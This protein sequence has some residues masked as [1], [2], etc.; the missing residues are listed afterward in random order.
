MVATA[1]GPRIV[2]D[3][4]LRHAT[5]KGRELLNKRVWKRIVAHLD[6]AEAALVRNLFQGHVERSKLDVAEWQKSNRSSP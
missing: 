1:Q 3:V 5:N 4:G 6:E 2:V